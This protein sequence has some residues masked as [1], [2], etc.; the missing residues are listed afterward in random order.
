MSESC[1]Q[2][3]LD[4]SDTV[5]LYLLGEVTLNL[6]LAMIWQES[7]P[8]GNPWMPRFEPNF[9]WFYDWKSRTPLADPSKSAEENRARARKVLGKDEFLCQSMSWG[10]L[11]IMGSAARER[12]YEGML[13]QLSLAEAGIKY[14]IR[15]LWSYGFQGGLKSTLEALNRYNGSRT[16]G[17]KVLKKLAAIEGR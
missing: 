11:Q 1:P 17:P 3:V 9:I 8:P 5:K 13:Y 7:Y 14:G 2:D 10:P 6:V 16:Y 4:Y 12:G 15:H